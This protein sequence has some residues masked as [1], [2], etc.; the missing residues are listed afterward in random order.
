M[1]D[2]RDNRDSSTPQHLLDKDHNKS[3]LEV[4]ENTFK[5]NL[6]YDGSRESNSNDMIIDANG[7]RYKEEISFSKKERENINRISEETSSRPISPWTLK[8]SLNGGGT[9]PSH[10][11]NGSLDFQSNGHWST[12]INGDRSSIAKSSSSKGP[13]DNTHSPLIVSPVSSSGGSS[14]P[15]LSANRPSQYPDYYLGGAIPPTK[16]QNSSNNF[17]SDWNPTNKTSYNVFNLSP[18]HHRGFGDTMPSE[19]DEKVLDRQSIQDAYDYGNRRSNSIDM[20]RTYSAGFN[21]GSA[22]HHHHQHRLYQDGTQYQPQRGSVNRTLGGDYL[23]DAPIRS[24]S[25]AIVSPALDRLSFNLQSEGSDTNLYKSYQPDLLAIQ[26]HAHA[27]MAIG[28]EQ[29]RSEATSATTSNGSEEYSIFVGDLCPELREEDL[30]AQFLQPSAWPASHPFAI[31]H[32]HAQQVQGNYGTPAKI[33]PAP[34]TST[35]SAKVSL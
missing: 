29:S 35:K 22:A 11:F 25:S 26:Q 21:T 19:D 31:A 34:F 8:S 27:Q 32:A 12:T 13:L 1:Q 24:T 9:S 17:E 2:F 33:R 18:N 23:L 10:L 6:M 20:H 28:M 4:R 14:K 7:R 16:H 3:S 5:D 15:S 30:V